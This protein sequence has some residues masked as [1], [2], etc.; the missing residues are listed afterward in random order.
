[1]P[2][3]CDRKEKAL[4]DDRACPVLVHRKLRQRGRD[5]DRRE[6]LI[7]VIYRLTLRDAKG[8]FLARSFSMRD[9][10]VLYVANATGVE[11]QKFLALV[12]ALTG[13]ATS[14]ASAATTALYYR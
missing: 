9:K 2:P 13:P 3:T 5:I 10:D 14:A 7:P 8:Y 12:G 1:M 6:K 4:V 11:L